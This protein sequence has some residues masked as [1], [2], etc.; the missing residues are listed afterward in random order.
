MLLK[1]KKRTPMTKKLSTI[2]IIL[3]CVSCS[4][5]N[6]TQEPTHVAPPDTPTVTTTV[7]PSATFTPTLV[8]TATQAPS[9]TP[10]NIVDPTPTPIQ[11]QT[12][13]E[14]TPIAGQ[15]GWGYGKIESETGTYTVGVA[16]QNVRWGPGMDY[17]RRYTLEYGD[18]VRFY[19]WVSSLPFEAWLCLDP[20]ISAGIGTLCSEAI[21]MVYEMDE[22]GEVVFD[23]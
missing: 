22:F 1:Q 18:T 2:I 6:G 10:T 5:P 7:A 16:V 19:A 3:F 4:S 23:D 11:T 21:A 13:E 14:V 20:P 17:P 12:I 15:Y 9:E 8:P